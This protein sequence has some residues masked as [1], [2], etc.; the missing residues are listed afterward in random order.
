L[1]RA[2]EIVRAPVEE[3]VPGDLVLLD[4][5][6]VVPA[7]CRLIEGFSL[8]VDNSTL[9]G[10]SM[11]QPRDATPSNEGDLVHSR[12]VLLAGTSVVS[13]QGK[14]VAFATGLS[15]EFGKAPRQ[16]RAA[17][18]RG[19]GGE[20]PLP[21]GTPAEKRSPMRDRLTITP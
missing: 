15:T 1:L 19:K 11:P 17:G 13:G 2:G 10:E 8:R 9:T 3:V 4:Q 18:K 12:N 20:E 5:G 21:E 7:D 6:D 14:A 16:R